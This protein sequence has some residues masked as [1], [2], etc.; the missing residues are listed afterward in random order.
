MTVNADVWKKLP[1]EVQ[2][3]LQEKAKAFGQELG[4]YVA[5]VGAT[6]PEK[7][8][9]VGGTVVVLPDFDRVAWAKQMPNIAKEWA[10][11]LEKQGLPGHKVLSGYMDIMRANNQPIARQW[12]KE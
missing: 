9:E 7:Y 2:K 6:A 10:D 3:V 1:P 5:K 4:A 12:D 8:R 11:S